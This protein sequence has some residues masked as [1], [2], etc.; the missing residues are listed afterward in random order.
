M[1]HCKLIDKITKTYDIAFN[2]PC[3]K[4]SYRIMNY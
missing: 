1:H 2:Y 3:V 4:N